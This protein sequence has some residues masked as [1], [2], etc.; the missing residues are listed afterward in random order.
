MAGGDGGA[1]IHVLLDDWNEMRTE[2]ESIY[3]DCQPTVYN[4]TRVRQAC[5]A[6]EERREREH[7]AEEEKA[8]EA[9]RLKEREAAEARIRKRWWIHQE[10]GIAQDGSATSSRGQ[11]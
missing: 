6:E 3:S 11:W 2:F 5:R 1:S 8:L 9:E 10:R 4:S 7:E